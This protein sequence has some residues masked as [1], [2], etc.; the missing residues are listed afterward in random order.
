MKEIDLSIVLPTL[1]RSTQVDAMLESITKYVLPTSLSFEIIIVDQNYS[2]LLDKIVEKYREGSL[3]INHHKVSFRGLSK[4]KNY[5][6]Q[7]AKGKYI[8]FVDDDAEFLEKTVERAIKRLEDGG[9]DIVSGRCVDRVGNDSALKFEHRER[10]LSLKCF[11]NQFIESTMFF[12]SDIFNRFKYDEEMGVGAFFGA[13]E[14]YDLVYRML[15]ENV[16][17]LFDP[18]ILF[19]HPQTVTSHQGDAIAR[20]AYLYRMGYGHLCWKHGLKKKFYSRLLK[21][22]VYLPYLFIF[23]RS[24]VKYY[25]AELIGLIAGYKL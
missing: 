20:R 15:L 16:K 17:I 25:I 21:V 11:E 5:G 2:D 23:K 4:A 24:D 9:F 13:E 7:L 10:V 1:G 19:Y 22:I 3:E 8:C 6:A 14:G 18:T 12:K